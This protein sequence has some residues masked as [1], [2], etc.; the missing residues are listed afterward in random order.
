MRCNRPLAGIEI[1]VRFALVTNEYDDGIV[2]VRALIAS[3]FVTSN[4]NHWSAAGV[5]ENVKVE[6]AEMLFV[7][8]ALVVSIASAAMALLVVI[9]AAGSVVDPVIEIDPVVRDDVPIEVRPDSVVDVA[10]RAIFVDPIVSDELASVAPLPGGRMLVRLG[11]M[12]LDVRI[13]CQDHGRIEPELLAHSCHRCVC[14]PEPGK[15]RPKK[16]LVRWKAGDQSDQIRQFACFDDPRSNRIFAHSIV[17]DVFSRH[18]AS[19]DK[20]VPFFVR[21]EP[22]VRLLDRLEFERE[23]I[24]D[25]IDLWHVGIYLE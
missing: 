23:L 5:A 13:L 14:I 7:L 8:S 6:S 3:V 22:P 2:S 17:W 10:P 1:D 11:M 16:L 20:N 21:G 24:R 25:C 18:P 4:E 12:R 9:S 19:G 15:V